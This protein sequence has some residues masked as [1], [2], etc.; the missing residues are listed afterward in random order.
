MKKSS[1][2]ISN[3]SLMVVIISI[4]LLIPSIYGYIKTKINYDILVYLPKD[5]ETI[6]GEN[7]LTD[8][9]SIGAFSF[10]ITNNMN[11]YDMKVLEDK[12]KDIS[13]VNTAL[14]LADIT[15]TTIPFEILPENITNKLYKNKESVI[16]VTFNG[17]TSEEKTMHA[18]ENLREVVGDASKVS[19]MTAM[20]LDTMNLSNQE[21]VAYIII[22]CLLCI[23]VLLLATDSYLI[24]LFLLG[25]IG[26]AIIYNMG[27]NIFLG[28][29]SYITKAITA[30]LQLGVT[31]DFSIFL[32]HKYEQTKQEFSDK[33]EAMSK[34]IMETFKSVIGSSLTTVAGFLALCFMDLTLGKDIGIVM[35]K[36]VVWGLIC[37]LT[38]FPSLLLVFDNLIEKTKH[39]NIFP[40][41]KK[42]QTFSIKYYKLI[43]GIFILLS[44]PAIYGNNN[45]NV[46]YKLDKS[47]PTD[48]PSS[49]ANSE[50]AKKFNIISPQIILLNKS[51]ND[52]ELV[53]L[54]NKIEDIDGVDLVLSPSKI[55]ELGLPKE[56]LPEDLINI[57]ENNNY[58]LMLINSTYEVASTELNNQ[59]NSINKLVKKYDK[60]AIIAGEGALTKDLVEIADHDFKVVNYISIGII[61][62]LMLL[63]LKSISLPF[64]LV[65][66]IEFAIFINLAIAY[67]TNTNLP[68]IASIV[69]GTIQLGAT[70][71]YAILMSTKYLET[72]ESKDKTESLKETLDKTVPSIIVSALCFFA[73]TFG[74]A[75]YSKID[76]IGSICNLLSRGAII[77]MLVVTLIL[78]VLLLVF[79]KLII[80]TTK[81]KKE[82]IQ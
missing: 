63:V 64:I 7:I 65:I 41:F 33:K 20:V 14:S 69:I 19:G 23:T 38:V 54:T 21:I 46:Y 30:V 82:G 60:N 27:S 1:K 12:I 51:I 42:I 4:L 70:I 61:F 81:I 35:A 40:K 29:I 49:I 56:M 8:K 71:D 45:Y 47:L 39:K 16:V 26:F 72:R 11:G 37:V 24:P 75:I 10:V 76:M 50:V 13:G 57:F 6:K 17:S 43:L 66:T 53:E 55:S 22:A 79:D 36:G 31:M 59:I 5:I 62:I 32:Y 25:N 2:F 67:Y 58:K 18:V 48:L 77:S 78:P 52:N 80:K 15:D 34:A 3:H 28:E 68:F 73:A 74:V 44:I 9:F